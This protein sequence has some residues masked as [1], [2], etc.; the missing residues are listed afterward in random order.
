MLCRMTDLREKE[1]IDISTGNRLGCVD[2]VEIDTCSA[3]LCALV[4]YGRPRCLGL[5]GREEDII[6]PWREIEVIGDETVLVNHPHLPSHGRKNRI[7]A[8]FLRS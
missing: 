5:L 6:I 3:Q 1:V 4:V 2:D 8:G 7:M